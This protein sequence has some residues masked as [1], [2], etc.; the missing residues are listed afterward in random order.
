MKQ[1]QQPI[2]W[3]LLSPWDEL[4]K[5]YIENAKR[6]NATPTNAKIKNLGDPINTSEEEYV[7]VISADES[8]IVYTYTGAKSKGGRVNAFGEKADVGVY[9]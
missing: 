8:M 4:L 5:K 6:Y 9:L 3:K 2:D 1:G 7:P